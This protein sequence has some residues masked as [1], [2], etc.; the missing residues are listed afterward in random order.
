MDTSI[1][2]ELERA[3]LA[4]RERRLAAEAQAERMLAEAQSEAHMLGAGVARRIEHVLA[5][6]R[7]QHRVETRGEVDAIHA[8]MA[9]LGTANRGA[10]DMDPAVERAVELV[11]E[12]VLGE[13]PPED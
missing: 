10:T 5:E 13:E 9:G 3:E 12:H 8:A 4:A 6:R 1:L 11:V 7:E 2:L